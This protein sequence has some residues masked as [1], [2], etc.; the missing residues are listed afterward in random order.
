[1]SAKRLKLASIFTAV[2]LSAL[3]LLS[4]T[5][6]WFAI[7]LGSGETLSIAGDVAAPALTA[8]A[9][10]GLALA[11][12]LAIAGPVFR[13]ILGLIQVSIGALVITSAVL[14]LADPVAAS[15]SEI[16]QATGI[17]G[18]ESIAGLVSAAVAS[19]W[20]AVTVVL[21]ILLALLGLATALTTRY[22]PVSSRKYQAVRL[23][24]TDGSPV[25]DWDALSDGRD[26]TGTDR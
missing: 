17:S 18:D 22:W 5:Q 9:L 8:L 20:P 11:G 24:E 26:P 25:A 7:R 12:A 15:A 16:T 14:A 6:E 4:W 19:P 23:E 13:V 1:M 2:G 10:S 3:V 21:G